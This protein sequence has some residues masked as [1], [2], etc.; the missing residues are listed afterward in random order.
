MLSITPLFNSNPGQLHVLWLSLLQRRKYRKHILTQSLKFPTT[1]TL[2]RYLD[3]IHFANPQKFQDIPVLIIC[4]CFSR[5][6]LGYRLGLSQTLNLID[7][8]NSQS[9]LSKIAKQQSHKSKM[10]A[11]TFFSSIWMTHQSLALTLRFLI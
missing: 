3:G 2:H 10:P 11:M 6:Y 8:L 7:T 1:F 9:N 4:C 5:S